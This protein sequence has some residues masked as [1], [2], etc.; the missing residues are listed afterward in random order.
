[1]ASKVAKPM[2]Q[3]L[4]EW[5]TDP[6]APK[7]IPRKRKPKVAIPKSRLRLLKQKYLGTARRSYEIEQALNKALGKK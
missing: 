2:S 1:M 4:D 6:K 5:G 7:D 3:L